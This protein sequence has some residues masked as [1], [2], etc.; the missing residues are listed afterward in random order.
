MQRLQIR[1]LLSDRSVCALLLHIHHYLTSSTMQLH[2][3]WV[4]QDTSSLWNNYV[5]YWASWPACILKIIRQ[6]KKTTIFYAS[7][8]QDTNP[9]SSIPKRLKCI[10]ERRSIRSVQVMLAGE[11]NRFTLRPNSKNS[12][13]SGYS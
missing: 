1:N 7:S 4:P 13:E 3:L 5:T 12:M 2:L 8:R 6:A 10:I 11:Q 9:V